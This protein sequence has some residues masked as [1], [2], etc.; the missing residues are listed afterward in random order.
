M[1]Q[2][3]AAGGQAPTR[4]TPVYDPSNG[5]HYGMFIIARTAIHN[6]LWMQIYEQLPS[7][8][9]RTM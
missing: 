6:G 4:Q 9:S 7:L 5:G 3:P 2:N 8:T 1:E